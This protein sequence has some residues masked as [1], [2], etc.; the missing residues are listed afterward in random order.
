MKT[1]GTFNCPDCGNETIKKSPNQKRCKPC[2]L[3]AHGQTS[4]GF[5]HKTCILCGK[6]YK[7]T[8]STQVVCEFCKPTYHAETNRKHLNAIRRKKGQTPVGTMVMCSSCG[9]D[10]P[11]HSGPQ[12]RCPPCQKRYKVEKIHEWLKS[13]KERLK[14]YTTKARDNYDFSGNRQKALERDNHTCQRCGTKEDLHVHHIDGNGV[15]TPRE[16][17]NNS[18]DNLITYCRGCH[19]LVHHELKRS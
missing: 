7:P 10:F 18:L 9:E 14:R 1:Y 3:E 2:A 5:S 6:T 8:G 17:R 4:S 19:T 13:D 16:Y 12:H 15:N 11:Y